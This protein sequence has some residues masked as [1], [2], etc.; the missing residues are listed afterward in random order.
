MKNVQLLGGIALVFATALVLLFF[1][2]SV[3]D[4]KC[5]R[6][7]EPGFL[8]KDGAVLFYTSVS[9]QQHRRDDFQ[10]GTS[11]EL[12]HRSC[13]KLRSGVKSFMG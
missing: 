6:V 5:A 8:F 7:I 3:F 1:L 11:R 4:N 9:V 10:Q 12:L 13:D 2:S